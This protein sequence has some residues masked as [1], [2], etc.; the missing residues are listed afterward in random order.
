MKNILILSP[1]APE[2][3]MGGL[4]TH[5]R[6]VLKRVDTATFNVVAL[7]Q[8]A[9][10]IT[11]QDGKVRVYGVDTTPVMGLPANGL[12]DTFFM[13]TRFV[14]R[15]MELYQAGTIAKPDLIHICDWTTAVAGEEIA[16]STGAKPVFAVHLSI[17]NYIKEVHP[18]FKI[19]CETAQQIEFN[20]C[21]ISHRVL[22]VTKAYSELFPF[23]FYKHKTVICP[24]GVDYASFGNIQP[25]TLPGTRPVKVLF[26]GRIIEMKNPQMLW[27]IDIPDNVDLI[28][29]GGNQGSNPQLISDLQGIAAKNEQVHY[30]G[31]KYG[32]EKINLMAAA[33]LVV[34]PS[35]HEPFG[36]VALE[37]LA[38]GQNGKTVLAASFVDGLGEFLTPQ[39]AINCGTT[40]QS[41]QAAVTRFLAMTDEEKSAM[42]QAGCV[43]AQAYS[44][45]NCVA[46]IA[47]VWKSVLGIK[48]E[49]PEA[50]ET[51]GTDGETEAAG[52]VPEPQ[53]GNSVSDGAQAPAENTQE[54]GGTEAANTG[55]QA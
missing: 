11:Y 3:C 51:D 25:A 22:Q 42:R 7:C 31:A 53:T 15:F 26:V 35:A 5:I 6:N 36:L 19:N 33:D 30:L 48:D 55:T 34:M 17:N 38:A 46:S 18:I 49:T 28:F 54:T 1:D 29:M 10:N 47:N 12:T 14:A 40:K 32:Q 43:I 50:G 21:R 23:N 45:A 27:S 8:G 41:I 37:A 16:R 13:Q 44:W 4:G 2:N 52:T 20:A 24:N 39:A 9:E